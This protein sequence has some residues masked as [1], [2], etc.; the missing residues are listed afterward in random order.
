[1]SRICFASTQAEQ[2]TDSRLGVINTWPYD[3]FQS[4][5]PSQELND[6]C[7]KQTA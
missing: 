2:S 3:L 5:G 6:G 4:I 1:M 7:I